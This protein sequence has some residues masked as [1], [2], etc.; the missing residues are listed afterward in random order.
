MADFWPG[1][2]HSEVMIQGY[3]AVTFYK[4]YFPT[5]Q[6][7]LET[8]E[9]ASITIDQR[10][11]LWIFPGFV[12]EQLCSKPKSQKV[13]FMELPNILGEIW[14]A[15]IQETIKG[16]NH[17][18]LYL[19]NFKVTPELHDYTLS[20]LF[21]V[22]GSSQNY[23]NMHEFRVSCSCRSL[24]HTIRDLGM[25]LTNQNTIIGDFEDHNHNYMSGLLLLN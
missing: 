4:E 9:I 17:T 1:R 8:G 16:V 14:I 3:G 7:E 11:N 15:P 20:G 18:S 2:L 23:N 10:L 21:A 24:D 25:K 13:D 12:G 6:S 19:S 5:Q 22:F